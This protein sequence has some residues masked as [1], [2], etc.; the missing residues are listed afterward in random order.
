MINI[1][2][3]NGKREKEIKKEKYKVNHYLRN[4]YKTKKIYNSLKLNYI[5]PL[6]LNRLIITSSLLSPFF[7][8]LPYILLLI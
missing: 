7:Q 3:L 6:M 5:R 1:S 4:I 2:N 8:K